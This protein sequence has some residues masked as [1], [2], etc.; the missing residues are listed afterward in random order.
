[1]ILWF[2]ILFKNYNLKF[3]IWL[4]G[5]GGGREIYGPCPRKQIPV[6]KS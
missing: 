4:E 2:K 6:S 3:Y 1:M 5:G